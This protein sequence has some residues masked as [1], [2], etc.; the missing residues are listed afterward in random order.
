MFPGSSHEQED[1]PGRKAASFRLGLEGVT[2]DVSTSD[3]TMEFEGFY[4]VDV[5]HSR[6]TGEVVTRLR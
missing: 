4:V 3:S 6:L 1:G 5:A 2:L